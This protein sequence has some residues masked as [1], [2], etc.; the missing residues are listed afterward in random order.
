MLTRLARCPTCVVDIIC[1]GS[2]KWFWKTSGSRCSI[3]AN[4]GVVKFFF[5][6]SKPE[7]HVAVYENEPRPFFWLWISRCGLVVINYCKISTGSSCFATDNLEEHVIASL[8]FFCRRNFP[9]V[10][11]PNMRQIRRQDA[12]IARL[13]TRQ[14][15]LVS[16]RLNSSNLLDQ[17]NRDGL[18]RPG[19]AKSGPRQNKG[20]LWPQ[21]CI[22]STIVPAANNQCKTFAKRG[23]NHFQETLRLGKDF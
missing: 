17:N 1:P 9:V 12:C 4:P 13:E 19:L 18:I 7:K 22:R 23:Q 14:T 3:T 5:S 16:L 11:F 15:V 21:V 6:I 2:R 8:S 20:K 10:W